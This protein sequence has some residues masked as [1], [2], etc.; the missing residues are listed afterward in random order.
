MIKCINKLYKEEYAVKQAEKNKLSRE[1]IIHAAIINFNESDANNICINS[2]CKKNNISKGLIYHYF[3]SKNDLFYACV[4][5]ATLELAESIKSFKVEKNAS[6]TE[7]LHNYY[8]ERIR[9]W[10]NNPDNYTITRH[11]ISQYQ[12]CSDEKILISRNLF[13]EASNNK[14]KD[15]LA[16]YELSSEIS[17]EN[18]LTIMQIIYENMF[19]HSMD[20]IIYAI[21]ADNPRLANDKSNELLKLYDSLINLLVNGIK[22]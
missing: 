3:K 1:K 6:L 8:V 20:K 2:I 4:L 13:D 9:F 22:K 18:L 10:C 19:M 12:A 16:L 21:K 7:N 14:L 17:E 15:I 11:A 5:Y